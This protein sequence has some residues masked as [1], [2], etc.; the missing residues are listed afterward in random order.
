MEVDGGSGRCINMEVMFLHVPPYP[1]VT[2]H[3]LI[4]VALL[5]KAL[6]IT[7]RRSPLLW[8]EL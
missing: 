5:L 1:I 4:F 3:S 8:A 6:E 7:S 2:D